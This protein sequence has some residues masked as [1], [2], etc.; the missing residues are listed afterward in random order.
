MKWIALFSQ[1]GSEILEVS[2]RLNRF[3]DKIITNN[4]DWDTINSELIN[5]AR[6]EYV[7]KKPTIER[8]LELIPEDTLT[9]LHGW[10]RII[11]GDVCDGRRIVN[12]H[13]G[14]ITE[15]PELKG[16]DPQQKAIDLGLEYS[17]CVIHEV[18]AEVDS[19]FITGAQK[20]V[21][22]DLPADDVFE[23]L[24]DA[25]IDLWVNFLN[26]E[27]TRDKVCSTLMTT[28]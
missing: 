14:L 1:T 27:F 18:V 8:Y 2:R 13:P 11:P 24:H 20:V 15:F 23:K 12:G 6:I 26:V 9:T 16:K 21:I 25:S 22:K 10:L 3:P 4:Q 28:K 7:E 17:G 19:G 5:S